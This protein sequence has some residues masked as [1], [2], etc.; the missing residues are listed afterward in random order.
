[1]TPKNKLAKDDK[2][3]AEPLGEAEDAVTVLSCTVPIC[4]Q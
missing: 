2:A 3:G 4:V 1:M